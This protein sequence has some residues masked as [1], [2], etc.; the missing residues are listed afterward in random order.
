MSIGEGT[1][2]FLLRYNPISYSNLVLNTT[3]QSC[4]NQ[5]F[6]KGPFINLGDLNARPYLIFILEGI[7]LKLCLVIHKPDACATDP[8]DE[9]QREISLASWESERYIF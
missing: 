2:L 5:W 1:F 9:T 3:L 4:E 8:N 6:S 7:Q